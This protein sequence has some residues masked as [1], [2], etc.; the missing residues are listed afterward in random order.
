MQRNTY[1]T[2]I[3]LS[4]F[5]ASSTTNSWGST[6]P[7]LAPSPPSS[8]ERK[9]G[10]GA[11]AGAGWV[12][13]RLVFESNNEEFKSILDNLDDVTTDDLFKKGKNGS[14]KKTV[15]ATIR[16]AIQHINLELKMSTTGRNKGLEE[17]SKK[18]VKF[19]A[20]LYASIFEVPALYKK[21]TTPNTLDSKNKTRLWEAEPREDHSPLPSYIS[22]IV[23][24]LENLAFLGRKNGIED[25]LDVKFI[26]EGVDVAD[27]L[28]R[29]NVIKK[30]KNMDQLKAH[31]LDH[32]QLPQGFFT[33]KLV[34]HRP[35]AMT[36][37]EVTD[38]VSRLSETTPRRKV[39]YGERKDD[40][41]GA[42]VGASVA[43]GAGTVW[44]VMTFATNLRPPQL[45]EDE[46]VF[47]GIYSDIAVGTRNRNTLA[48]WKGYERYAGEMFTKEK[49][50]A[51]VHMKNRNNGDTQ[52]GISTISTA[53]QAAKIIAD[54]FEHTPRDMKKSEK[55]KTTKIAKEKT[56]EIL[57]GRSGFGLR[58]TMAKPKEFQVIMDTLKK[59]V[60]GVKDSDIPTMINS[61]FASR[62]PVLKP[63][64]HEKNLL[65][66]ALFSTERIN[67]MNYDEKITAVAKKSRLE[68]VTARLESMERCFRWNFRTMRPQDD[69]RDERK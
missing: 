69:T 65:I 7:L 34:N 62:S 19:L 46:T 22:D 14:G 54:A 57:S 20:L 61:S 2:F 3:S 63:T 17:N 9:F 51:F 5:L 24:P 26:F 52:T 15:S 39:D 16:R 23:L 11:A 10:D 60:K 40:E 31:L 49:M 43:V 18:A 25:L 30:Y 36:V 37:E 44:D 67:R 29:K 6:T 55:E 41:D 45:S 68:D 13:Q 47:D 8:P 42:S 1:L 32:D 4:F 56:M 48:F 33:K 21:K 59:T 64:D 66:C 35:G 27:F 38:A 28:K 53:L 58:K 12:G 50:S